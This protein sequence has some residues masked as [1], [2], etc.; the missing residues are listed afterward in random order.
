MSTGS[1]ELSEMEAS[2]NLP[3]AT[4]I[5]GMASVRKFHDFLPH[6]HRPQDH[7][8]LPKEMKLSIINQKDMFIAFNLFF[9]TL[10]FLFYVCPYADKN[11]F[12]KNKVK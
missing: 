5:V 1:H 6:V 8:S 7:A 9:V 2:S 12:K 3:M 11:L 4:H 10:E